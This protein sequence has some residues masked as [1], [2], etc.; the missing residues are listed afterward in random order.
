MSGFCSKFWDWLFKR[1]PKNAAIPNVCSQ[2][3]GDTGFTNQS[4]GAECVETNIET[5]HILGL[6]LNMAN[7]DSVYRNANGGL[8]R[9]NDDETVVMLGCGH[10]GTTRRKGRSKD[11]KIK[12]IAGRCW[13]CH[14]DLQKKL[15][16]RRGAT[17]DLQELILAELK[18]L[19][20]ED[21]AKITTSGHIACAD[22]RAEVPAPDGTPTYVDV[23]QAKE[24]RRQDTVRTAVGIVN[25][26]FGEEQSQIP[27]TQNKEK[28]DATKPI[29]IHLGHI[30]HYDRPPGS[31]NGQ[32]STN[33][34]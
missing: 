19:V 31:D 28:Q 1:S 7:V 12:R 9:K 3:V 34:D 17:F 26:L 21:C 20:C 8:V 22:H 15:S 18:T 4:T 2:P 11:D 32:E 23:E 27:E 24:V 5:Q 10:L 29:S 6:L 30:I 16:S 25:Y 14:A 33:N 13:R